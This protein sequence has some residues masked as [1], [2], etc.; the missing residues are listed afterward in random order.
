[1]TTIKDGSLAKTFLLAIV[2]KIRLGTHHL[3]YVA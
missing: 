2:E 3:N 1:L